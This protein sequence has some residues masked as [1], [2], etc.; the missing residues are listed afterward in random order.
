MGRTGG[1]RIATDRKHE[2]GFGAS[3]IKAIAQLRRTTASFSLNSE[4]SSLA[5]HQPRIEKRKRHE[6]HAFRTFANDKAFEIALQN[7]AHPESSLLEEIPP[8]FVTGEAFFR[9]SPWRK[10]LR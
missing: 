1:K 2:Y 5:N 9:S 4:E 8:Q 3:R 7:T 10:E 6:A